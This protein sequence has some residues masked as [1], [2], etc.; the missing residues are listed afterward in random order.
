MPKDY[1]N[2]DDPEKASAG[3]GALGLLVPVVTVLASLL[4]GGLVGALVVLAWWRMTPPV[5][6]VET[7]VEIRD[8]TDE[9]IERLC[10]PFVSETVAVLTEAQAKVVDLEGKVLAKEAEIEEMERVMT[11]RAAAGRRMSAELEA[12]KAELVS[13]R[14]QLE[15]AVAEK[16]T[17]LKEL[18]RTTKVLKETEE[19]LVQTQGKLTQAERDVLNNRWKAFRQDAQLEICERGGRRKMGRCREA[20]EGALDREVEAKFRHCLKSGQ[21]V[22]GLREADRNL[23]S[24]PSHSQWLN[25]DERLVRG[26][27]VVLCDPTLPE[28]EDFTQALEDVQRQEQGEEGPRGDLPLFD[29]EDLDD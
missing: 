9:E 3:R 24:L 28:A 12:A 16:E 14:E 25:Q 15:V 17:A 29:L 7:R 5:V 10:D 11:Q 19:E 8:M 1:D 21:A 4:I 6:E 13:L 26:W 2:F 22:P 23:E 20:V 27:F 18:E